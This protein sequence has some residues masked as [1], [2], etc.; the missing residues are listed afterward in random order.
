[1]YLYIYIS[2]STFMELGF[3][4]LGEREQAGRRKIEIEKEKQ[5][6]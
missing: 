1:M 6:Y 4:F 3:L 2:R 5:N